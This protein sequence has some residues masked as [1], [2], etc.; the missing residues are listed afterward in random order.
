MAG[1][2][3]DVAELPTDT[4]DDIPPHE[5]VDRNEGE[6]AAQLTEQRRITFDISASAVREDRGRAAGPGVYR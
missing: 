5:A 3:T 2:P 6:I 4:I 1:R